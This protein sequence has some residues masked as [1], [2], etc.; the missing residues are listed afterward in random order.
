MSNRVVFDIGHGSNT[1]P[2]NKGIYLP[3]GGSFAEHDFN[4]AVAIKAKRLAE[5]NGFEVLLSQQ[6]YQ[7]DVPL[8]SRTSYINVEHKKNP[9]LCCLSFH[10]N[11]S[12][13]NSASGYGVFYWNTSQNGKR[14]A[15]IWNKYAIQKLNIPQWGSGVWQSKLGDWTNFHMVRE[16]L[17]P[18]ILIE[19]FFFTN[20]SELQKCNTPGFIDL[21]AEVAVRTICDYAG[22]GFKSLNDAEQSKSQTKSD[23]SSWAKEA[24]EFVTKNGISDGTRPKDPV[25]REEVWSMLQRYSVIQK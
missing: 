4:A 25:T 11:A 19:H 1:F 2:P 8:S 3:G 20:P 9:I 5:Y 18:A 23:V 12:A 17:M 21:C 16:T 13:N 10:A 22:R 15:E 24:Y 7:K 14:L 6:P